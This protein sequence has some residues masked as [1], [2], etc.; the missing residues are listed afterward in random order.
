MSVHDNF[1][2]LGGDSIISIQAVSRAGARGLRLSPRQIF[3]HPTIAELAPLVAMAPAV[4]AEQGAVSG[5]V[6]LTP[7]QRWLLDQAQPEPQHYNQALL[8]SA[9]PHL[10]GAR[11][12][13]A[14]GAL[15]S[16]HD[17]LRLR[18]AHGPG[19]WEQ[20]IAD[21]TDVSGRL[22][23]VDISAT[24][25]AELA[26][27]IE[28]TAAEA[29]ASLDLGRGPLL[30][31]VW[32]DCGPARPGRLL[33][34][35]HHLAVDGVSWRILLDDLRAVY[36]QGAGVLPPKTS[37]YKAWAERLSAAAIGADLAAE[38]LFWLEAL[39]APGAALPVD[40]PDAPDADLAANLAT[41]SVALSAEETRALILDA[42]HAHNTQ[43]GDLLLTALAMTL[44][45][46]SGQAQVVVEL[47]GH[48]RE[49]RFDAVDLSRTVGWFTSLY[50]ARLEPGAA[51]QP[52]AA[53]VA[54]KEQLRRIPGGGIGYGL[55]RYLGDAQTRA[56]LAARGPAAVL[57]N[58]LGQLD[59]GAGDEL[60]SLADEPGGPMIS[61]RNRLS[62]Q[63]MINAEVVGGELAL[64]WSYSARRYHAET[65]ARLAGR[66]L[67]HLR[68]LL[69]H[70]LTPTAGGWTP[71]DFTLI[72][73]EQAQIERVARAVGVP[74]ARAARDQIVEVYPLA[75]L[76]QGMLFHSLQ[77]PG[78]GL[79]LTQIACTLEGDMDEAAFAAAWRG[80]I[81]QTPILRSAFLWAEL[82]EPAQVVLRD[83]P[84]PIE[85][86]DWRGR[87][88][89]E[90]A[91][92]DEALLAADAR[93]ELA[94][95]SPPLMRLALA[96]LDARRYRLFWSH[97]HLLLDGWSV[98]LILEAV[99]G[100]YAA[101]R[102]GRAP[103]W[104]PR[105]PYRDYIAWLQG[106]D[107]AAAETYW[108]RALDGFSAPTPLPAARVAADEAAVTHFGAAAL[109]LSEALTTALRTFAQGHQLTLNTLLQGAWALLLSRYSREAE[110][111]FGATVSGR[112][113]EL[114]GVETM[115]GLFINT[116]PVRVRVDPDADLV[117]WLGEIQARQAELR[118]FEYSPLS[119]VQ[120]WSGIARGMPLFE[121]IFVFENYPLD[122][123]LQHQEGLN[124]VDVRT[125]ER[126]NVPLTLLA[127][128]GSQLRLQANYDPR[129]LDPEGVERLLGQLQTLL[130]Q[131]AEQPGKLSNLVL[132]TA[133]ERAQL[134]ATWN[135]TATVFPDATLTLYARFAAQV[136]RTPAAPALVCAGQTL[137][138]AQLFARA[139][140]LGHALRARGLGPDQLV[141]VVME[142]SLDLV[143]AL[144]GVL[145]AG[146]AYL[147]IDPAAPPAR[148]AHMLADSQAPVLL[149][150][151]HLRHL[152]P[153][154][155]A[156]VLCLDADWDTLTADLPPTPPPARTRPE[157][158]AYVI[159][160]SGSTGTP[161][162]AMNAHRAIGNRL[163][164]MQQAY[165]LDATDR[166]LQKTPF[167]FD[168][169]VWEFFWPLQVGATLV[170]APP[171]AHQDSAAL[172]AL[173]AAER[174]STIHFVPSML[175]VFVEEPGLA[176][177][178][179]LRRV[180]CSGEALPYALQQRF[181]ARCA[182]ELHNLYGPTEAAVD[183]SAWACQRASRSPVVPIGRPIANLQLYVLDARMQ[184][185][186]IG[187][188]GE[189]YL[190]GL[191]LG[192]GYWRRPDLTAER[193]GP[194]P[195]GAAGG[196]LYRTGDLAR[197][198]GDGVVEYL[199]RL[200][201]QVKLHGL[202]I[203][204][205]EIEAGLTRHPAVRESVVLLRE[206][207]PGQPRLVAY[208]VPQ[209]AA[210]GGPQLGAALRAHLR[211]LVPE[212]MLP[213]A[214]VALERLPLSPNG[215]LERRALPAPQQEPGAGEAY[216]PPRTPVEERLAGIWQHV[217]GV[218]QVGV[219]DNFFALG[220]DSILSLQIIAR[221]HQAGLGLSPQQIFQAPT[222]AQ[223][224]LLVEAAPAIQAE[225]G[226]VT[227]PSPLTPIQRWF[228]AR[229][230]AKPQH[231]NQ[232]LL[233]TVPADLDPAHL[234]AALGAL[235]AHHD[236]LR[237]RF[238]RGD[239]GAWAQELAAP[240]QGT[241][242][243]R[244]ALLL[245]HPLADME[246]YA[247]ALQASL[248]LA[249]GP[250]L[251]A[252]LYR[253][254]PDAPGRLLL[255]AHHLVIDGVSWRVLLED[256]QLAYTQ[257]AQ[258]QPVRLLPKTSS[259]RL[260]AERLAA[261]AQSANLLHE[262]AFWQQL[263]AAPA[264]ALPADSDVDRRQ[265]TMASARSVQ[266][267]L[268][269]EET[270]ALLHEAHAAYNTQINDLL[271]AA[272]ARTLASWAGAPRVLIELEGH[273]REPL[274]DGLDLSRTVG[275]FTTRYPL[276][277]EVTATESG[278]LIRA[279]K[280]QI[281]RV[282]GRGI[283]YGLLRFLR[284]GPEAAALAAAPAPE[285]EF[286]YLGQLDQALEAEDGLF[287]VA[288]EPIGPDV[289]PE[290]VM[291]H[292]LIVNA[293]VLHGEL[294]ATWIYNERL[295]RRE[296]IARLAH[297]YVTAL[298]DLIAHC[299]TP[300]VGGLTPSDVPLIQ[301]DDAMLD[302]L[303]GSVEF[304]G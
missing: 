81:A 154:R 22:T 128:P 191:G 206:D 16:H 256:L 40:L 118:Q 223:L 228:F 266:A 130:A 97:H 270:R 178:R 230:L 169:S 145:A 192:R 33:L 3:Q 120:K 52:G 179:S 247:A 165:P 61:P 133:A 127:V 225:Q 73:L 267:G 14:L 71:S 114:P 78:E 24:V 103:A 188:P 158:L 275:W 108:R 98:A 50:P 280:E 86:L 175:Q 271:L 222:V 224:A 115:A 274:F 54:V 236:A 172:A 38:L 68:A 149:T 95:A 200:D 176:A 109:S 163:D 233:L 144:Y 300:G 187:V 304:E 203:E 64:H 170:V 5:A 110:V 237:S 28:R 161:K 303:M 134:L 250:L 153:P 238:V 10:D 104:E 186:G 56:R 148:V 117:P 45:E 20:W 152:L 287:S 111:L 139:N 12:A 35:I 25:D 6:P 92:Q 244:P 2:A 77:T 213:A 90:Q 124:I 210:E 63:L 85:R 136:A 34:V 87:T 164:W 62:H 208:V 51:D 282:P 259:Y 201:F 173:V 138:Y 70:C 204:L 217:L 11:L 99:F 240:D 107:L 126:G 197:W 262:L 184:P 55:L 102:E 1:F 185:V 29:Q 30:R 146:A 157:H 284:H 41:Q 26:A 116:L 105:R 84:L 205:G 283:G 162:G 193:F 76:Q 190:G 119:Q 167:S 231:F 254:E 295:H 72:K 183:V 39:P 263:A 18:F 89:A 253:G 219:N 42:G 264:I 112:P 258:G 198:R 9:P 202:R 140:Q 82:D 248:D 294:C 19:G 142:R 122:Q 209:T 88:D 4:V 220:G 293:Q 13:A 44:G 265:L 129:R 242:D 279:V 290:Q 292:P 180:I 296:T 215:K 269:R 285:L 79:Y 135:A 159:Y 291:A 91:E 288:E 17:A 27:T 96:R 196:R 23:R 232:A 227:G 53:L 214:F 123:A 74:D 49:D 8:L 251:R 156:S 207:K 194:D 181:F 59:A 48:G 199:G 150:Q 297:T 125:G 43:V 166:V 189:L 235:L 286:N 216:L 75:P 131:M 245:L 21:S 67:A 277:L 47:E 7:I 151:A 147:P 257:A 301:L 80:V 302:D 60:F 143:V 212:Y 36:A 31:A 66:Y 174:I 37:S 273:G 58:Y 229:E 177:C 234:Q 171:G 255:V 246:A 132:S 121:S 221:A 57:F 281:R 93:R 261:Y 94:F 101:L 260:W 100:A 218:A 211:G 241:T 106:Q 272:L 239:D 168:V 46:W 83:A 65:V 276:A 278:A 289:A 252:A 155:P 268:S 226:P 298:R 182:A 113:P 299:L 160:T 195:Y 15:E 69:A 243:A 141:A 32:F 249:H 137:S